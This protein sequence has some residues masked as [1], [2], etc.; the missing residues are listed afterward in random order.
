[1]PV[2]ANF[3]PPWTKTFFI[4][5]T[6]DTFI[7]L[8]MPKSVTF[9][10]NLLE[11]ERYDTADGV[12]TVEAIARHP[13]VLTY[14]KRDG[15][16]R[17]ELV[18][19]ELLRGF[20]SAGMPLAGKLAGI[21]VSNEHPNALF[22]TLPQDRRDALTKGDVG[23]DGVE[24]YTDGRIKVRFHVTDSQTQDDIR[25][26][27]KDGVSLGYEVGSVEKGGVWNGQRYDAM[28]AQPFEADHL[29]VVKYP[30]ADEARIVRFDADDFAYQVFD[31]KKTEV[32]MAV[33]RLDS[34]VTIEAD[35]A[36]VTAWDSLHADMKKMSKEA[37]AK[38]EAMES[39]AEEM[40]EEMDSLRKELSAKTDEADT[41]LIDL[42]TKTDEMDALNEQMELI[43]AR[44]D[45][46]EA[47][48][49]TM[50]AD[51]I[52]AIVSDRVDAW[53]D[54][55][56]AIGQ[57][58][59]FDAAGITFDAKLDGADVRKALLS[60]KLPDMKFDGMSP[61][62]IK[63][64]YLGILKA[65]AAIAPRVDSAIPTL[66]TQL[67][68]AILGGAQ[69]PRSDAAQLRMDKQ[70]QQKARSLQPIHTKTA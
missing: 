57:P 39:D 33:I 16:V 18:P 37:K 24:V 55:A 30:R 58:I 17:R 36:L 64:L 15:S 9:R 46:I 61:D 21:P 48:P 6:I 49:P 40:K 34:G 5:T 35:P 59:N 1:M 45:E 26:G 31:S 62:M 65:P 67:Q 7:V 3:T 13:G 32:P 44:V 66:T 69:T 29:A 25:S 42:S 27:R 28:Q 19:I 54:I 70:A 47:A 41:L 11:I 2:G 20:D 12:M 22:K 68:A 52:A 8:S 23:E 43:H 38:E 10:C 53:M 60:T 4:F 50:D 51:E 56:A 63:G 14:H